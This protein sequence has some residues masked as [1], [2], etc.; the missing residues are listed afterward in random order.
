MKELDPQE[1]EDDNTK[2]VRP[3]DTK[4]ESPQPAISTKDQGGTEQR[5]N[6]AGS[7]TTTR[8]TRT[9]TTAA[10]TSTSAAAV[11]PMSEDSVSIGVSTTTSSRR[12]PDGALAHQAVPTSLLVTNDDGDDLTADDLL[13][14][15]ALGLPLDASSPPSVAPREIQISKDQQG[16]N[17]ECECSAPSPVVSPIPKST[18][19]N[20][21]SS[22]P[23]DPTPMRTPSRL[24]QRKPSSHDLENSSRPRV[25]DSPYQDHNGVQ[26]SDMSVFSLHSSYDRSNLPPLPPPASFLQNSPGLHPITFNMPTNASQMASSIQAPQHHAITHANG[27]PAFRPKQHYY[28]APPSSMQPPPPRVIMDSQTHFHD[29]KRTIHLRLQEAPGSSDAGPSHRRKHSFLSFRRTPMHVPPSPVAEEPNHKPLDRGSL[30]V[31]WYEGTTTQEL[32]EHVR[33][34]VVR[35]LG[36]DGTTTK[37]AEILLLDP[38]S[39]PPEETV[40]SPYIPSG[41]DLVLRFTTRD[42]GGDVTP[43][44]ASRSFDQGPPLSPS[45]APSPR[46]SSLDLHGLGLNANQLAVLGDRLKGVQVTATPAPKN[47]DFKT[48][49]KRS[50]KSESRKAKTESKESKKEEEG[51]SSNSSVFEVQSLHP[52]DPV[53]KSLRNIELLLLDRQKP[54]MPR[55]DKRQVITTLANY[56]VLFLSMV[57]ISAEI[58]ARVPEWS[59]AIEQQF[60][61]V[62]NCSKDQDA[63]FECVSNGDMAGLVASVVLW[64]SRSAATKRIFLFGFDTP[65]KLWTAVYESLVTAVCWGFSYM[66]IRRGLNPDTNRNFLQ[67]YWKDAVYG[68]LAG[69]NAAFLKHVLKN[70]IPQEAIEDALQEPKLKILSWLPSFA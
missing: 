26:E 51:E 9:S 55:Q 32:N 19:N 52:E 28:P 16:S 1:K 33:S 61:N 70:L 30:T 14:E 8:T 34:A 60:N 54:R 39:T 48:P 20:A 68:S 46:G 11:L 18:I 44:Y 15:S 57:A 23:V 10:S 40:L 63:L 3:R 36:L 58:Q 27:Y 12:D 45:A 53:Q 47:S 4:N 56:F 7:N 31:S 62:K 21:G 2:D 66:F 41:S 35:K 22:G 69:F 59:G 13:D 37:L 42:A 38:S 43:P 67:K 64:L 5:K 6:A 50:P 65:R 24:S 17:D 25:E 29:S 49:A